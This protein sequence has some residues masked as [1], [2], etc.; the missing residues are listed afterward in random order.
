MYTKFFLLH[1]NLVNLG[2]V[3]YKCH[4]KPDRKLPRTLQGSHPSPDFTLRPPLYI[5]NLNYSPLSLTSDF[6]KPTPS[7]GNKK[8]KHLTW[9]PS[10]PSSL[11]ESFLLSASKLLRLHLTNRSLPTIHC[12]LNLVIMFNL[13]FQS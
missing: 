2:K 6:H 12:L 3:S 1:P 10:P 13:H 4:A 9:L 8:K 5:F 11:P 7:F